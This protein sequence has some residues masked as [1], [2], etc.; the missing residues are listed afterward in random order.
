MRKI[1]DI[2]T[3]STLIKGLNG[4]TVP[5]GRTDVSGY[6]AVTVYLPLILSYKLSNYDQSSYIYSVQRLYHKLLLNFPM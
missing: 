5:E 2:N 4:I 3:S 1:A 6:M